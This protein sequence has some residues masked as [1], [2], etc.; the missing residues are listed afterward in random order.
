MAPSGYAQCAHA[1][2]LAVVLAACVSGCGITKAEYK[3]YT[4]GQGINGGPKTN[5]PAC[6]DALTAF[7]QDVQPA[8]QSTCAQSSCHL[9]NP[10]EGGFLSATDPQNNL[11]LLLAYTGSTSDKLFA[12]ISLADGQ[13]H[14]GGDVSGVLPK[15][16]IDAWLAKQN[17]CQ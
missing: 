3:D 7:T 9:S 4:S 12:H 6:Q 16:N 15:A 17:L 5:T 14:P 13:G 10:I 1:A 2:S 11:T 8:I